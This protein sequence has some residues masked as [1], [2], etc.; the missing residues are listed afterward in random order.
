[1]RHKRNLAVKTT[2][3]TGKRIKCI[4]FDKAAQDNLPQNIKDKMVADRKKYVVGK[5]I[6]SVKG[7]NNPTVPHVEI[8]S[9]ETCT[10]FCVD[11]NHGTDQDM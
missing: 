10:D 1:M 3:S 4:T 6:C 5:I 2:N 11:E 7:C 8:L 9:G